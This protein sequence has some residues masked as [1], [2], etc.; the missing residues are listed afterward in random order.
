MISV[1]ETLANSSLAILFASSDQIILARQSNLDIV[2][3]TFKQI[4]LLE[5][6]CDEI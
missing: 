4:K 1:E 5:N 3:A 6:R 2:K